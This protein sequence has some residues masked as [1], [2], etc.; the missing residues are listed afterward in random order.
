MMPLPAEGIPPFWQPYFAVEYLEAA[1]ASVH[2][3]GG[4][5]LTEPIAVPGGAF[6][7]LLDTHGAAFSLLQGAL[8]PR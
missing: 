2:G 4:R 8:D 6:I 5:V 1:Q 3:L 7:A